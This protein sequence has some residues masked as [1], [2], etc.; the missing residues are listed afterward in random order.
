MV[1]LLGLSFFAVLRLTIY[2]EQYKESSDYFLSV[3]FSV[4]LI[5]V[6]MI[7]A[8]YIE[9]T[10]NLEGRY[11]MTAEIE[12]KIIKKILV[13]FLNSTLIPFSL[14]I[15][16]SY[17]PIESEEDIVRNI[18]TLFLISNMVSPLIAEFLQVGYLIKL[19]QRFMIKR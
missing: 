1:V 17:R 18:L 6:N 4:V 16:E 10:T 2:E 11:N 15:I 5:A 12:S 9:N 13:Y 7:L 14:L 8:F 19:F 3:L